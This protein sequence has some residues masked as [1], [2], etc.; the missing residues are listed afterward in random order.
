MGKQPQHPP[1]GVYRMACTTRD[2][3]PILWVVTSDNRR[4]MER[5]LLPT[6]DAAEVEDWL[7]MILDREDPIPLRAAS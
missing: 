1:R 4:L 2:G 6:D 7:W 3:S 5:V